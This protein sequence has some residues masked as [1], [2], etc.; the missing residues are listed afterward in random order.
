MDKLH[1]YCIAFGQDFSAEE[2]AARQ[3]QGRVSTTYTCCSNTHPNLFRNSLP[4]EAAFLPL[5]CIANH[6]EGYLHWSWMNWD[7]K[8][9]TDS[10]YRL[11]APGDTYLVYPGP[12]SSVRYERFIEG[13]ALAEKVRLLR[14]KYASS[15]S[16]ASLERLEQLLQRCEPEEYPEG[17]T[18]ATLVNA[19]R[20][21]VNAE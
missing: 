18:A 9:L 2:L 17:E 7:D 3:K 21:E 15:T 5:Y 16:S 19:V 11:F 14:Q 13:V 12:Q 6:F 8:S 10:R 20:R 1:D 4:A